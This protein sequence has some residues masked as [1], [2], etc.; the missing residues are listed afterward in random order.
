[1]KRELA[2]QRLI[3]PFAGLKQRVKGFFNDQLLRSEM[4]IFSGAESMEIQRQKN[5][6]RKKISPAV[7]FSLQENESH[8][9]F[10]GDNPKAKRFVETGVLLLFQETT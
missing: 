8:Y 5:H 4:V 2:Y 9:K 10:I 1:M 7:K 6:S 3:A